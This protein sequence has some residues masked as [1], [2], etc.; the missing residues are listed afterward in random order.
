MFAHNQLEFLTD[1]AM[2]AYAIAGLG[3]RR[4]ALA[5]SAQFASHHTD[6]AAPSQAAA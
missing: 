6:A 1:L 2:L 3:D 5:P 4:R